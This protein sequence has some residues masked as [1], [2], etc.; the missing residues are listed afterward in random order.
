MAEKKDWTIMVYL[1]GDNNLSEDMISTLNGLKSAMS[2]LNCDD[3]INVVAVYD[4]GYPT[5]STTHYKFTRESSNQPLEKSLIKYVHPQ[6]DMVDRPP[7]EK[8][9][10]IDFVRWSVTNFEAENYALILSGHSDGIIGRTLFKDDNPSENLNLGLLTYILEKCQTRHMNGKK[11][12]LLGFDSC[13]MNM[14]EVGY[15]L[16]NYADV[17]VASQGNVPTSG[18]SYE[19]IFR[20]VYAETEKTGSLTAKQ[21]ASSIVREFFAYSSD[22]NVG[23][24]SINISACDMSQIDELSAAVNDLAKSFN[25]VFESPIIYATD[26]EKEA[27]QMNALMKERIKNLVHHSHYYSQTFMYEQA[28]DV[29]DFTTAVYAQ[30]ELFERE[31]ELL[32]GTEPK[33]NV[34]VLLKRKLAEIKGLCKRVSEAVDKYIFAQGIC[35]AEFQF[36]NG[37]SIFFPWTAL[38]FF[39]VYDTYKNLYFSKDKS[40]WLKFIGNYVEMTFRSK[41]AKP[42]DDSK[43]YL[44]WRLFIEYVQ[45]RDVSFKDV[46]FKDVSFKDVSFKDV[47]FKDVSFKDVSFKDVSF[48]DLLATGDVL[49]FYNFFRRFRN[50]PINHNVCRVKPDELSA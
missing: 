2:A 49:G 3:K 12:S 30:C 36:S 47:S 19:R 11:F 22:Y 50:H 38:S 26:A 28:V 20:A 17:I 45:H 13:L 42:F 8:N 35:G 37:V 21:F 40:E 23:G 5:V 32:C 31:L 48:K 25:E 15:Q 27:A 7:P 18:W 44:E 46:S 1:A 33:T 4:S 14:T 10:I 9:Y 43:D 6:A 24:R 39:M 29:A 41:D 34:A 16:R